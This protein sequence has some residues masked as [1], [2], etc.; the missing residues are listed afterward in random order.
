MADER[1]NE[2]P[3][4]A[5]PT[6]GHEMDRA[7]GREG[8]HPSPGDLAICIRCGAWN[9]FAA[10]LGLISLTAE[11]KRALPIEARDEMACFD[12][13]FRQLRARRR[14]VS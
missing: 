2:V 13:A 10:N 4:S 7:T 5:C 14:R 1:T 8:A 9:Q 11:A 6:C 3:M 12:A